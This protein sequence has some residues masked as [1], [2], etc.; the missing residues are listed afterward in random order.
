M[1]YKVFKLNMKWAA[2]LSSGV[3]ICG[4]SA[5]IAT[6]AAIGAPSVIPATISSIIVLFTVVE[7][8]ILPFAASAFLKFCWSLPSNP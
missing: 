1:S 5:A 8:V 3:S 4:V 7:L 6:A 2:T